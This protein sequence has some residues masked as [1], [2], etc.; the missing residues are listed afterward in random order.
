M[1][2]LGDVDVS[3]SW[4]MLEEHKNGDKIE[5]FLCLKLTWLKE[6]SKAL[7]SY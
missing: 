5:G 2:S 6:R 3:G 4:K 1:K 7:A